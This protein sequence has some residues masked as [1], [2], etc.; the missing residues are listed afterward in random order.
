MEV[1]PTMDVQALQTRKQLIAALEAER[2]P[3][4]QAALQRKIATLG[5][6][7]TVNEHFPELWPAVD[8]G[9][10][11]CASL[12][13]ADNVNPVA[14]VYVGMPSS[15]KTTVV[16]MFAGHD[17]TYASDNFTPASFVSNAANVSSEK[18]KKVDLLPRIKHKVLITPELA[19]LFR[20]KEDELAKRFAILTRVLD[21]QGYTTDS[22]T[23][24]QRGYTGDYLFAWLGCTTPLDGKVWRVM[25]QLGSRLFFMG[26]GDQEGQQDLQSMVSLLRASQGGLPYNK[27]VEAC[28]TIIHR[29]L[30]ALHNERG[31]RGVEWDD[32]Q[33]PPLVQEY[34]MRL[35]VLLAFMRSGPPSENEE[36]AVEKESPHRAYT[37]LRHIARG[38]ALVHGRTQLS[39]DD[40]SAVAQVVVSTMPRDYGRVFR[41]LV[42]KKELT[43]AQVKAELGVKDPKTA[44]KVM[45]A[46]DRLGIVTLEQPGAGK[47]SSIYF[48]SEWGWCLEWPSQRFF[49]GQ[50]INN[51]PNN[52]NLGKTGGC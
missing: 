7:E 4:Q 8:V 31:V 49:I 45:T 40:L 14:V 16:S 52:G 41:A 13:L 50:P 33:D 21:G 28:K 38:H 19:P 26:V 29:L 24:G 27:R 36:E 25:A 42:Q 1:F 43:V 30:T 48:T 51:T 5:A 10:S 2:S 34:L 35:A 3:A 47:A 17:L 32:R 46:L 20:G 11:V 15:G 6:Q 22:G 39:D 12:L 44:R 9:L 23:H 37:V 18:L